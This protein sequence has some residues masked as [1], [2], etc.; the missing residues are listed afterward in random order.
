M[1]KTLRNETGKTYNKWT[2]LKELYTDKYGDRYFECKCL[3]GTV[4]TVSLSTLRNNASKSCGCS[5]LDRAQRFVGKKFGKLIIKSIYR[6]GN[7][8]FCDCLC[9]CGNRRTARLANIKASSPR[10]CGCLLDDIKLDLTGKKFGSLTVKKELPTRIRK[11][12]KRRI[13]LCTCD[14]GKEV[15]VIQDNLQIQHTLSCGCKRSIFANGLSKTPEYQ[16]YTSILQRCYNFKAHNY[17]RYGGR[18]IT[19]CKLWQESFIDFYND[20]VLNIGKRP[21]NKHSIDRKNNN[22]GYTC[23]H[24][25]E[26]KL[27]KQNFNCQWATSKQQANNTSR[28]SFIL[29]NDERLTK[30]QFAEKY[31]R[32]D[33]SKDAILLRFKRKCPMDNILSPMR[34]AKFLAL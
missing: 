17:H 2:L 1:Q 15:E 20:I 21:S 6:T 16:I 3:C 31:A 4:R 30:A 26:C 10:S 27:K 9:D 11:N 14:C 32:P 24:C 12:K 13:W 5:R 34:K 22:Q 8:T 25:N 7:S 23:G 28:N 19:L 29:F 18:G 33:L